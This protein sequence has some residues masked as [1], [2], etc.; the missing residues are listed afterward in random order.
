MP[1]RTS[2]FFK[3][4]FYDRELFSSLIQNPYV[5]YDKN[6]NEFELFVS[7]LYW[8]IELFIPYC[9][10]EFTRYVEDISVASISEDF[11]VPL[12]KHQIDGIKFGISHKGWILGD[13]PGLGKTC[14]MIC[15]AE[16]L[17]QLEHI[18]HCLIICG[19]NSLKYNWMNEISIFSDLGCRILGQF[20]TKTGK[21]AIKSVAERC[22]EL[23]SPIEEFFVVTNVE[24]LQSKDFYK[25]FSKSKN[26]FGMIV[27]DEIHKVKSPS[28]LSAKTLLKLKS[29]H[30]IG[31]TGTLLPSSPNDAYV[32]LKWTDNIHCN[33]TEFKKAYNVFGGFNSVQLVGYKNLD[34][35]KDC[36]QSSSL[37]RL[38]EDV[39]DLP[40][41]TLKIEYVEMG[42]IQQA[43]YDEVSLGIAEEL[44]KLPP[45]SK[46]T[47]MQ[48]MVMHLRQ[49]Q[50]TAFPGILTSD[51]VPSAKLD[52][53]EELV[54]EIIAQDSK[55][56]VYSTFK[57]TLIEVEK[58]LNKY[59][60]IVCSGD[61]SDA[62]IDDF[63]KDF[64]ENP[65]KKVFVSTWQKMGTGHTL[66]SANYIIFIDTPWTSAEFEQCADRI[67]RIGQSKNV[68]IITLVTKDT[69]DERV[70]E[71]IDMKETISDYILN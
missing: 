63:K 62:E 28:S 22:A 31:L 45:N 53:L 55:V 30:N 39:L 64:S 24:T 21:L 25:S 7:K 54:E 61:N 27:F 59:G 47:I 66:V 13:A 67:H 38:K 40:P 41:K 65:N 51:D 36:I 12:F 42:E 15:L 29:N 1:T 50:V 8:I 52:R 34:V 70:L 33:F 60:C 32:P 46:L 48:E 44:D 26:S 19:V 58:R 4:P 2:I 43:L 56:V 49:R 11:K 35:L 9:S 17:K 20:T 57:E 16:R 71:I 18:E 23:Q 68:H 14:Q 37:R 6:T 5:H 69:Y 3:L 10:I